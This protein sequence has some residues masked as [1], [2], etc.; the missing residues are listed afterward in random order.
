MK[1]LNDHIDDILSSSPSIIGFELEGFICMS[2]YFLVQDK[3][4]YPLRNELG[5][6]GIHDSITNVLSNTFEN[7]IDGNI[8]NKIKNE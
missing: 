1:S 2:P 3:L 7:K 4:W 5:D 6:N 8:R